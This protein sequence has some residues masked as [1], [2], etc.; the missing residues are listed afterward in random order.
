MI[1]FQKE[2][3]ANCLEELKILHRLHWEETEG[4]R[5]GLPLNPDYTR[6]LNYERIQYYHLFTARSDADNMM[7][8]NCGVYV[9]KSM[10]TQLPV[11]D[12]RADEYIA[13]ED[14]LFLMRMARGPGVARRF[15]EFVEKYL[16]QQMGVVEIRISVKLGNRVSK[17][18]ESMGYV[19][20]AMQFTKVFPRTAETKH[21]NPEQSPA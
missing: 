19:P 7:V 1:I 10:H 21:E 8:G 20:S 3:M 11:A 5:H 6:Y 13:N 4:Y 14:T 2:L 16:T 15:F 17:L 9:Q 12:L 18:W